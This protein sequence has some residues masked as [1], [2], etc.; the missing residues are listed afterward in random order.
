MMTT[1][2]PF[3]LANK[4]ALVAACVFLVGIFLFTHLYVTRLSDELVALTEEAEA[5]VHAERWEEVEERLLS[6]EQRVGETKNILKLFYDHEDVDTLDT[7]VST[8]LQ[9]VK[10]QEPAEIFLSLEN[11]K[12]IASY[13]AGI[14][15]FNIPNLF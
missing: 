14:E 10:V 15:T 12:S 5:F 13:L 6:I 4:I 2:R 9:L 3:V 8:A 11:I 1:A 7:E